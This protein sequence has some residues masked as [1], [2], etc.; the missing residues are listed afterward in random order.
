[1]PA[2]GHMYWVDCTLL[3]PHTISVSCMI[4][5]K[6][7][8]SVVH[9]FVSTFVNLLLS[10]IT[11]LHIYIFTIQKKDWKQDSYRPL[12]YSSFHNQSHIE[13]CLTSFGLFLL[14]IRWREPS[15]VRDIYDATHIK[16]LML[17]QN[18]SV[19]FWGTSI[20]NI[21]ILFFGLTQRFLS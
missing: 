5:S 17:I 14:Q 10:L 13:I 16:A 20:P 8:K 18:A 19:V 15:C 4:P 21:L 12:L 9:F 11:L 1:M 6:K 3:K 2:M 7:S